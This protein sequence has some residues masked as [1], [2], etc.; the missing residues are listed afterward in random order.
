MSVPLPSPEIFLLHLIIFSLFLNLS[1]NHFDL[2]LI[3]TPVLY[4]VSTSVLLTLNL[5][6]FVV[7]E[8]TS[9]MVMSLMNLSSQSESELVL[10]SCMALMSC[11]TCSIEY[12]VSLNLLESA[13]LMLEMLLILW[14]SSGFPLCIL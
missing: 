6:R 5:Y 12:V 1:K 13:T 10:L 7:S 14:H 11:S 3:D 4:S 2:T 8:F 9:P